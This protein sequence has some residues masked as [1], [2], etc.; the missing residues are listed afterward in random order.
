VIAGALAIVVAAAA[1]LAAAVALGGGHRPTTTLRVP[2]QYRTIQAAVNAA[3]PGDTIALAAG[4]FTQQVTIRKRLTL[5]GASVNSTT[6]SAPSSPAPGPLASLRSIVTVVGGAHVAISNLTVTGPRAPSCASP[7]DLNEGIL[8]GQNATLDLRSAAVTNVRDGPSGCVR[9]QTKAIAV[10]VGVTG[11]VAASPGSPN[12]GLAGGYASPGH[13]IIKADL[14][15]GYGQEG[16]DIAGSGSTATITGSH[17]SGIGSS[18]ALLVHGVIVEFGG[19]AMIVGNTINGNECTSPHA[20]ASLRGGRSCGPG[21][22]QVHDKGIS[23]SVSGP[24]TIIMDNK[25]SGND[26]GILLVKS[27]SCC[28]IS[29]NTLVGNRYFGDLIWDSTSTGVNDDIISGSRVG[30]GVVARSGDT[31][32]ALHSVSIRQSAVAP[33][34]TYSCCGHHAT[35]VR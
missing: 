12:G 11:T 4:R 32:V 22:N 27:P 10:A 16:I 17:I 13:A 6:V 31:A 1:G 15:S 5:K 23:V 8:V 19:T 9:S 14:I 34:Q 21:V 7:S 33:T 3:K 2:S 18:S 20:D 30:V 29:H 26:V 28:T 25:L 24:G 35:V